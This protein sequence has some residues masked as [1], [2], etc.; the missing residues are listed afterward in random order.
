MTRVLLA[1]AVAS[2]LA[3]PAAIADPRDDGPAG[4]HLELSRLPVVTVAIPTVSAAAVSAPLAQIDAPTD[5]ASADPDFA[6]V[7]Q[8]MA[9]A[10]SKDGKVNWTIAAPLIVFVLV[11]ICRKYLGGLVPWFGTT[12]GG[13]TLNIGFSLALAFL[14][15][16]L[17]GGALDAPTIIGVLFQ[18][19]YSFLVSYT[20]H[21]T[22]KD[23]RD[24]IATKGQLAAAAVTTG[25]DAA[26]KL[27]QLGKG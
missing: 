2:L 25:D 8:G 7:A 27:E 23:A 3:A 14:N 26:A 20:L 6:V 21:H 24:A 12:A 16:G 5:V 22:Q 15:L 18:V 11:L 10:F 9:K 4:V 17:K 1:V 13:Y 19:G